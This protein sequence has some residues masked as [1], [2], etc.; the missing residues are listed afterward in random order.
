MVI[1]A[2]EL[3][4]IRRAISENRFFLVEEDKPVEFYF[5]GEKGNDTIGLLDLI[6]QAHQAGTEFRGNAVPRQEV[7][8]LVNEMSQVLMSLGEYLHTY[9]H[10]EDHDPENTR[11]C[12]HPACR[13]VRSVLAKSYE[14]RTQHEFDVSYAIW[15]NIKKINPDDILG[16]HTEGDDGI[17][18]S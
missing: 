15:D 7:E 4:E 13:M 18:S 3:D 10:P 1:P 17:S 6:R 9:K 16:I 14:Y 11:G 5:Y 8:D 12:S 2:H